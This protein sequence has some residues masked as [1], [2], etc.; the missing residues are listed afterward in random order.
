MHM[1]NLF[2]VCFRDH[3][4]HGGKFEDIRHIYKIVHRI[5][6][7]VINMFIGNRY[8]YSGVWV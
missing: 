3:K 8:C 1:A 6:S 7:Y 2:K 4:P 5:N